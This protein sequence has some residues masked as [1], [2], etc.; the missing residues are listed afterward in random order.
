VLLHGTAHFI[1]LFFV[2]EF[3]FDLERSGAGF[4]RFY[5][6]HNTVENL[7]IFPP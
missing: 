5:C 4:Q 7:A 1:T 3:N 2:Q 6:D